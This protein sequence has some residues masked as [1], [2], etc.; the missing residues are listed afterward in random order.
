[1]ATGHLRF[2]EAS[3]CTI[4]RPTHSIALLYAALND[5]FLL[6]Y[7]MNIDPD[8]VSEHLVELRTCI[9]IFLLLGTTELAP[10]AFTAPVAVLGEGPRTDSQLGWWVLS[11]RL[12]LLSQHGM[13]PVKA[14]LE[15]VDRRPADVL[16]SGCLSM[17]QHREN[18]T[19]T[20]VQE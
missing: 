3:E 4:S 1:M 11:R 15:L 18:A 8:A 12:L 16:G 20:D 7:D 13:R 10:E 9:S 2:K 5:R 19:C 6:Y 17:T 14:V